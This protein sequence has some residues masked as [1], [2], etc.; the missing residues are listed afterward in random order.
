MQIIC[1]AAKIPVSYFALLVSAL[2]IRMTI[3]IQFVEVLV[4]SWKK[5]NVGKH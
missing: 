3:I 5:P 1:I 4:N 2:P